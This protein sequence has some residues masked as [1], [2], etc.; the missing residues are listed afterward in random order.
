LLARQE[1]CL[2]SFLFALKTIT[3]LV[4]SEFGLKLPG[5]GEKNMR[6]R[7]FHFLA[8]WLLCA[9]LPAWGQ[10]AGTQDSA[11][12]D[13][14]SSG[15]PQHMTKVPTGVI[16]VKGA[17]PSA[18]D[19]VTPLPEDG[20]LAN[21]VFNDKYF[22]ITWA[23]PPDWREGYKGPPPSDTGRYVLTEIVPAD[24]F[25][26][27]APGSVLITAD[28]MFFTPFPV[29]SSVEYVN[30]TKDNLQAV[31]K[32]ERA[33]RQI[34]IGGRSF[35]FFAYWSPAAQLHWYVLAT[36]IRCHTVEIVLSSRDTKLLDDLM[37]ELN[38]MKLPAEDSLTQGETVPVCIK[39][40]ASG[41]NVIARVDPILTERRFNAIPVR[42]VIDKEG[43]I[44]HIHFLRA[45]PDQATAVT[46][47][48]KQWKFKPYLRDGK[49]VEV[50]TGIMF[51]YAPR[52]VI[53]AAKDPKPR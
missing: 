41:E 53:S 37:R 12:S 20:S 49:P 8:S 30:Y 35:T 50:E 19:S 14:S 27:P 31:Y 46:D 45:F 17:W 29:S 47:A 38:K 24:T 40:Y 6:Y 10:A 36:Q 32:V 51:G 43:R 48:L 21:N 7:V 5:F 4:V 52:P 39:D 42:I 44:K 15:D 18:S 23:L 1:A 26:G 16:L 9:A 34:T 2:A 28:D 11:K 13:P 3:L 22:G 25:K 33:P